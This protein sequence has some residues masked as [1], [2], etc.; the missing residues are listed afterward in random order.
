M[1]IVQN[2]MLNSKSQLLFQKC[3][4][5]LISTFLLLSPMRRQHTHR[6]QPIK[7]VEAFSLVWLEGMNNLSCF[8]YCVIYVPLYYL[9]NC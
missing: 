6:Q 5:N 2:K 1:N 7:H 9:S 4:L 8:V 3:A